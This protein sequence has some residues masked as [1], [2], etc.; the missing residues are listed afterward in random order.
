MS[1]Q[2]HIQLKIKRGSINICPAYATNASCRNFH[3]ASLH[4]CR[5]WLA[6]NCQM[7]KCPLVHSLR[8][9]QNA[10]ALAAV[11]ANELPQ[12]D[13]NLRY[14]VAIIF[15]QL[16]IFYVLGKCNQPKCFKLH[17]CKELL[18]NGRCTLPNCKLNHSFGAR[19]RNILDKRDVK[20]P[21]E[22]AIGNTSP[23]TL[24]TLFTN[25]LCADGNHVKSCLC[26]IPK[27][28]TRNR[29]PGAA[30]AASVADSAESG[31]D[32][33]NDNDKDMQP[34][35]S[36]TPSRPSLESK[37]PSSANRYGGYP[38]STA[39]Q[40]SANDAKCRAGANRNGDFPSSNPLAPTLAN[41]W[42]ASSAS[43]GQP[44]SAAA[45]DRS[46]LRNQT[47]AP[48]AAFSD[49]YDAMKNVSSIV[50]YLVPRGGWAPWAEFTDHF[51]LSPD[52]IALKQWL[53][54]KHKQDLSF[55][56]GKFDW[57]RPINYNDGNAV[58]DEVFISI[59]LF[60]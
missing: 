32:N 3:C 29:S 30:G 39:L 27:Q 37:L 48:P 58:P 19:E 17:L 23:R 13:E 56:G 33:S 15:P 43:T 51:K 14:E 60:F 4:V 16:C 44:S 22:I 53:R 47:R 18:L 9:A 55:T 34:V 6:G 26:K 42:K 5:A 35:N 8:T 31:D 40:N 41:L 7:F 46:S 36:Q 21:P 57:I 52:F 49:S 2:I 11:G 25:V 20:I 38:T 59:I 50:K 54:A 24:Q 28:S 1:N 10:Q 45:K 12:C